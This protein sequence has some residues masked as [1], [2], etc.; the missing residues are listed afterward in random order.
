MLL[1]GVA[2]IY[3]LFITVK[4]YIKIIAAVNYSVINLRKILNVH[5]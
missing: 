5:D 1:F 3:F 4:K 2:N